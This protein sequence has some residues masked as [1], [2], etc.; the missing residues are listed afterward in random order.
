[1]S[2]NYVL[3]TDS[4]C[5]LSNELYEKYDIQRLCLKVNLDGQT[6]EDNGKDLDPKDLY[7]RMAGGSTP[8][9]MQVNVQQFI[10]AFTP[11]LKNGQD[12]L[13]I[14]FS[15]GLSGTYNSAHIAATEL[16]DM[17]PER[18]IYTVDSLCAAGGEGLLV[19]LAAQRRLDGAS[20]DELHDYAEATKLKVSHF[21][22]VND[23]FHLH[24]GG[25][26]SKTSAII[27]T[28]AGIKPAMYVDNN[29]KLCVG[30]KVR[31]RNTALKTIVNKLSEL[32]EDTE[33]STAVINH[34]NAP[35][36]AQ[37]VADM[38][39]EKMHFKEI[40]I[41][42]LGPVIGTHTGQGCIAIFAVG[43]ERKW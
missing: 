19:M 30:S 12:V 22:T 11:T 25:R 36:E 39:M 18:K 16:A 21:F 7:E 40:K 27:G 43:S 34:A 42:P 9:T 31:G 32:A 41:L 26:V 29:G 33:N 20:I 28:L 37:M 14:G 8:T 5:D 17:F 35:E 4:T 23:L 10:D 3:F 2:Y 15:T 24:R 38:M 1:M 6:Y 13:Y